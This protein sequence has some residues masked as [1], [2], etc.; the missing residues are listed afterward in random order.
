[1]SVVKRTVISNPERTCVETWA[2]ITEIVCGQNAEP[3]KEF[4]KVSNVAASLLSEELLKDYPLIVKGAG[5]QLRIYCLYGED[6]I[7]G[8]DSNE[9]ILSW[10]ITSKPWVVYLPC[11]KDEL[12]WYKSTLSGLSEKFKVYD[13]KEG[14]DNEEYQSNSVKEAEF[15]IDEEA[16]KKL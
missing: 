3:K 13:W 6:A 1:M 5:A 12:S 10:E 7:S 2:K 15:N 11:A 16:F 14:I 9:D 8:E 4:E